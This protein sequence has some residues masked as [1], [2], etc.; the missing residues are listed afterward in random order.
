MLFVSD[1]PRSDTLIIR[2]IPAIIAP[3]MAGCSISFFAAAFAADQKGE[4][5]STLA[6]FC[7]G[8]AVAGLSLALIRARTLKICRTEGTLT[9]RDAWLFRRKSEVHLLQDGARAEIVI[10]KDDEND[11]VFQAC[12]ANGEDNIIKLDHGQS[13]LGPSARTV[14]AINAWMHST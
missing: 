2:D 13:F 12:L 4:F 5:G 3:I 11:D 6:F 1:D 14:R 8:A 9:I 7:F 10:T